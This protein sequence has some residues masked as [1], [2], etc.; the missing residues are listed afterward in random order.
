MTPRV[1]FCVVVV[2]VVFIFVVVLVVLALCFVCALVFF[3]DFVILHSSLHITTL[4]LS[5]RRFLSQ[6]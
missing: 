6:S 3:Y 5:G 2:V 1:L 4:L